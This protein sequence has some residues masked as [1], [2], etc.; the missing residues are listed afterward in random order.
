ME[1]LQQE[2]EHFVKIRDW[3]QYHTPKNLAM[4]LSVETAELVEI[5]QWLT[6]EESL[7]LPGEKL[8][9][10]EEE[11]GDIM[12]YLTTLAAVFNLDPLTAAHKKIQKNAIK[13]PAP[14]K[15]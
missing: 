4:A 13:Y 12:I 10:L 8:V 15:P 11:I 5:F 3:K 2:I 14:V 1:K 7:A 9:H 6:P